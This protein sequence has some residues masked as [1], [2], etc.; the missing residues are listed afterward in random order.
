MDADN[1]Q[2]AQSAIRT[3]I[4]GQALIPVQNKPMDTSELPEQEDSELLSSY[5]DPPEPVMM[6]QTWH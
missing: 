6:I 1:P 2:V 4:A 3:L 5:S